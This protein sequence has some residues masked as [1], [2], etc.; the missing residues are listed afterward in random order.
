[1]DLYGTPSVS[2]DY[3]DVLFFSVLD[4]S[5][6][7]L[8]LMFGAKFN[9]WLRNVLPHSGRKAISVRVLPS[10]W[11]RASLSTIVLASFVLSSACSDRLQL[12]KSAM[13]EPASQTA[14]SPATPAQGVAM[15]AEAAKAAAPSQ[16]ADAPGTP[17]AE[18]TRYIALRH[19]ITLETP[20]AKLK[21]VY[22]GLIKSCLPTQCELLVANYSRETDGNLPSASLEMRIQPKLADGFIASLSQEAEVLA[23]NRGSEDRTDQVIDVEAQMKNL[24]QL[25]DQLRTMLSQK[26]GTLKD[27]LDVQRELANTQARLDALTGTR[28]ALANE[29][30]KVAVSIA[31]QAKRESLPRQVWSPLR[32]AWLGM[33]EVMASSLAFIITFAAAILPWLVIGLPLV[34]LGRYLWK[35]RRL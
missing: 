6:L 3:R 12:G 9:Q 35:R 33:G 21:S 19:A 8:L 4:R 5:N 10:A 28:K 24:T 25:R 34:W 15:R 27:T 22:E 30:E 1:V 20:S 32:D 11:R 23:H 7:E 31:M 26:Q 14:A 16:S 29:T 13:P 17:A 18:T 2:R